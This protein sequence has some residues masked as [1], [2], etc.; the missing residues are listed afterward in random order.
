MAGRIQAVRGMNDVLPDE[1][2]LWRVFE[3]TVREVF[4]QYGYRNIRTPI[5]EKTVPIARDFEVRAIYPTGESETL[6][7]A[8]WDFNWQLGYNFAQP[9]VLPKGTRMIAISHFD[10]SP[11]NPFNPDPKKEVRWGLQNWE[12]MSNCFVGLTIDLKDNPD[13]LFRRSGPSLLRPVAGQA[14]PTLAALEPA[15]S[16]K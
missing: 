4:E 11:N 6:L 3:D 15:N 7:K 16:T 10:N 8:K 12:E 14:G 9:V 13:K 1:A 5:V 2:T